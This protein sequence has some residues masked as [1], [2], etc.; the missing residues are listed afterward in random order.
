MITKRLQRVFINMKSNCY[1]PN[2]THY[3]YYGGKGKKIC[4]EW[5]NNRNKF[6]YWA[7]NNGYSDDK[8]IKRKNFK[9]DYSPDNCECVCK[10][11]KEESIKNI[12][13]VKINGVIKTLEELSK[14][15]GIPYDTINRRYHTGWEHDK[16]TSGLL[17]N[18]TK[19]ITIGNKTHTVTEW[20]DISGLTRNIILNR[21]SWGWSNE[22][23]LLPKRYEHK[24]KYI[25][26]DGKI[27]TIIEWCEILNIS[28]TGF[29][30]K[31]KNGKFKDVVEYY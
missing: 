11:I 13:Q 12:L 21:I 30:R 20:A 16:L 23:L 26:I 22:E 28:R 10:K 2:V 15:S 18:E 9:G 29:S 5:L 17:T 8:F 24:K 25:E 14:E 27:H 19:L 4:D 7:L 1:N 3:K 31:L 6:Y